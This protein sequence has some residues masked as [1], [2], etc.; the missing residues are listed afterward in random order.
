MLS[1]LLLSLAVGF[2][3]AI[4]PGPMLAVTIDQALRVG[5]TAGLWIALGHAVTELALV[6]GLR[7]GLG[8]VLQRPWVRRIIGMVGGLVLLYFAWGMFAT[9]PAALATAADGK[10]IAS[11]LGLFGLGVL[12]TVTQPYWYLW[13]ATAGVGLIAAQT[14]KYGP[15]AWPAFYVGHVLADFIWFIFVSTLIAL[16]RGFMNPTVY[17]TVILVCAAGVAALGI[18]FLYRQFAEW[19]EAGKAPTELEPVVE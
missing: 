7:A 10:M 18:Y 9:T 14:E 17:R 11:R 19:H 5:W 16:G 6:G 1:V 8:G 12:V 2:S 15:R 3:G 13:W 4:T